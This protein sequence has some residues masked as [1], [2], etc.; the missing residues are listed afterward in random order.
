[1][2]NTLLMSSRNIYIQKYIGLNTSNSLPFGAGEKGEEPGPWR[3]HIFCQLLSHPD[4][5]L[6]VDS[7]GPN[8]S[9]FLQAFP[10]LG[11]TFPSLRAVVGVDP[12]RVDLVAE[13][14]GNRVLCVGECLVYGKQGRGKAMLRHCSSSAAPLACRGLGTTTS[15]R[16]GRCS[17]PNDL[18]ILSSLSHMLEDGAPI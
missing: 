8:R 16:V 5:L 11:S 10:L 13:P 4:P 9:R 14:E 7:Q 12:H 2:L 17:H 1:M 3:R 6:H 18:P 15:S